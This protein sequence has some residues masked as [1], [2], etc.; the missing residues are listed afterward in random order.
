MEKDFSQPWDVDFI[1]GSVSQ[2]GA[3]HTVSYLKISI[4]VH[5]HIYIFMYFYVSWK[6]IMYYYSCISV[7]KT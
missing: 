3:L 5:I 1:T 2:M 6:K 7:S 4:Y